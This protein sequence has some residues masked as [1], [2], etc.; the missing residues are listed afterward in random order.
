MAPQGRLPRDDFADRLAALDEDGFARFV[1]ALLGARGRDVERDGSL[2]SLDE[3]HDERRSVL[4]IAADESPP[5]MDAETVDLVATARP[6]ATVRTLAMDAGAD[7]LGPDELYDLLCYGIDRESADDLCRAHLG[8]SVVATEAERG[9][10]ARRPEPATGADAGGDGDPLPSSGSVDIEDGGTAAGTP[11]RSRRRLLAGLVLVVVLAVTVAGASGVLGG[12]GPAAGPGGDDESGSDVVEGTSPSTSG[13]TAVTSADPSVTRGDPPAVTSTRV[14]T[15]RSRA[16]ERRYV[17]LSPTCER[18][19]ELVAVVIVGALRNND[20]ATNDG[21]RTAWNFSAQDSR[22]ATYDAFEHYLESEAFEP[23]YAYRR[24]EIGLAYP[25][26]MGR[27]YQVTVTGADG[28]RHA[29][30]LAFTKRE[31]GSLEGCWLLAGIVPQ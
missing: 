30:H 7:V 25:D 19:P 11:R 28:D 18:P 4:A 17:G 16:L 1:A 6:S 12:A 5:E 9:G 2:L 20:P 22:G 31:R 23:L 14:G 26:P 3:G 29:Y 27:A 21:I 24:L 13:A 8:R 15:P 10:S